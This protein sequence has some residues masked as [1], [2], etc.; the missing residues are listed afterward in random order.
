MKQ[1]QGYLGGIKW[2]IWNKQDDIHLEPTI[3]FLHRYLGPTVEP[4]RW[5]TNGIPLKAPDTGSAQWYTIGLSI[6][7]SRGEAN[8]KLFPVPLH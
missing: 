1:T 8:L 2:R 6:L 4:P 5:R 7:G 3:R